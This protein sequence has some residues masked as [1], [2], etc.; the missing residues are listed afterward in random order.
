MSPKLEPAFA[1][2]HRLSE[3]ATVGDR[4][5]K[6]FRAIAH[7]IWK[8]FAEDDEPEPECTCRYID[9]DLADASGCDLHGGRA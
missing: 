1:L 9:V 5:R 2:A 8:A 4:E 3:D 6:Y 7:I